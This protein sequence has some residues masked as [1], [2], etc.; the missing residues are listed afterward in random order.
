VARRAGQPGTVMF[1]ASLLAIL[2]VFIRAD[3]LEAR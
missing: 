1:A 2:L 3:A